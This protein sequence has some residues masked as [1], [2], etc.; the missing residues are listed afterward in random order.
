MGKSLAQAFA[1]RKS[2]LILGARNQEELKK[3]AGELNAEFLVADVAK[4]PDVEKLAAFAVE[5]FGRIDIWINNAGVRIIRTPIE[6]IDVQKFHNMMETNFFG[7]FYG[8]REALI[9]MKKQKSGCILNI[10]S[11]SAFE[12]KPN[13][14]AYGSTKMA[15]IGFTKY[16]RNEAKNT[17]VNV[18]SV[19]P[20]GLRTDFHQG[21]IPKDYDTFLP[22]DGVAEKIVENLETDKPQEEITI[23]KV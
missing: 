9:Q 23:L 11:T 14:S 13:S 17:G 6:N 15:T 22:P 20:G 19:F 8:A 1:K 10:L 3:I 5:K 18:I 4:E 7:T 21:Q 12:G 2:Q 16:L